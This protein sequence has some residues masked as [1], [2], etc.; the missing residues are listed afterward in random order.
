MNAAFEAGAH[1]ISPSSERILLAPKGGID[2]QERD[3]GDQKRTALPGLVLAVST[4]AFLLVSAARA[5]DPPVM[6]VPPVSAS[7]NTIAKVPGARNT[8]AGKYPTFSNGLGQA[9]VRV[10]VAKRLLGRRLFLKISARTVRARAVTLRS[11]RLPALGEARAA[12][13]P[14][15]GSARR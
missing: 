12:Q 13:S 4:V 15:P 3:D 8:I 2:E 14:L 6:S 10:S 9:T 1:G 7:G 11:V 5:E